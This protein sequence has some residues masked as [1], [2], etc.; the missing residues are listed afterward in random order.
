MAA[1]SRLASI[2]QISMG[3]IIRSVTGLTLAPRAGALRLQRPASAQTRMG[4]KPRQL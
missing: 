4:W 2:K 3:W 1:V